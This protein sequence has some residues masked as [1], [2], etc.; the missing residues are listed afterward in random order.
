VK[1]T[2]GADILELSLAVRGCDEVEPRLYP[3]VYGRRWTAGRY[4]PV[5]EL[6]DGRYYRTG[7]PL[8]DKDE[9]IPL[10]L[11]RQILRYQFAAGLDETGPWILSL[12]DASWTLLNGVRLCEN[13]KQALRPD[14]QIEVVRCK[15]MVFAKARIDLAWLAWGGGAVVGLA[16]AIDQG[17]DFALLPVLADAMEDAG[18][19]STALLKHLREPSPHLGGCFVVNAILGGL[20]K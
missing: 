20:V 5:G 14:D 1:T 8:L 16:R 13:K 10:V 7:G 6:V 4:M 15:V 12:N 3:L 9:Y 2:E 18:C 19:K 11:D 17:K